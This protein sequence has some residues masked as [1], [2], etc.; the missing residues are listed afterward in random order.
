MKTLNITLA[1]VLMLAASL[2]VSAWE[3]AWYG[4]CRSKGDTY[5]SKDYCN[6]SWIYVNYSTFYD[7]NT[8]TNLCYLSTPGPRKYVDCA[9]GLPG[10]CMKGDMYNVT[11]TCSIGWCWV[12]PPAPTLSVPNSP[13]CD[14]CSTCAAVAH[15]LYSPLVDVT[16]NK[17][18]YN[19]YGDEVVM[20]NGTYVVPPGTTADLSDISE[21]EYFCGNGVSVPRYSN[22]IAWVYNATSNRK[23]TMAYNN[24]E[25]NSSLKREDVI[26]DNSTKCGTL[27][28]NPIE[29]F[30][31]F[32]ME[33]ENMENIYTFTNPS[34]YKMFIDLISGYCAP[35]DVAKYEQTQN[36]ICPY[37]GGDPNRASICDDSFG[38]H[39]EGWT[40]KENITILV[41]NPDITIA[42]PPSE[43]N[44]SVTQIQKNW[45][46]NNTGLG[47][48]TMNITFDCGNWTC[49]FDGY[50]GNPIP[51]E[52]NEEYIPGITLN[53]T[54]DPA[55]PTGQVGIIITYDEDYGLNGV[56]PK[57]KT[58]Y[59]SLGNTNVTTTSSTTTTIADSYIT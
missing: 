30:Y 19:T 5:A 38:A 42:A 11:N 54:I 21:I 44:L 24:L 23:L 28:F 32:G 47:K 58:S 43:A 22:L 25:I 56:P 33:N 36:Y 14:K 45:S 20:D 55:Q 53:I 37:L 3:C 2:S 7:C 35:N 57:T 15:S 31:E 49:A 6:G 48:T 12:S 27:V 34:T 26:G 8:T 40:P 9:W 4:D 51:L 17:N 52:E 18:F 13:K 10:I 50:N 59:I 41:P 1:L 39:A 29:M 16:Y 46:I